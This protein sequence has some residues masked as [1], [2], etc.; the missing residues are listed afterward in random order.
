MD[1]AALIYH[2]QA[3]LD[4]QWWLPFTAQLVHFNVAHGLANLAAA[5][6][7]IL[8]FRGTLRWVHQF[9]LMACS[10]IAVAAVVIWD[11]QCAYYAGASGVLYGWALGGCVL[12]GFQRPQISPEARSIHFAVIGL[13]AIRMVMMFWPGNYTLAWGFP[14]YGPAHGAGIGGGLLASIALL[15]RGSSLKQKSCRAE[16]ANQCELPQ[17]DASAATT[18]TT[19]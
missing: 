7:L 17:V 8:M 6:F 5:A 13:I 19:R 16:Q 9:L 1:F 14:V 15:L 12:N 3:F 18:T 4:G 10:A 2:R 11:T